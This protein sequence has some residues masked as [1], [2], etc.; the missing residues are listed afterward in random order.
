MLVSLSSRNLVK[1]LQNIFQICKECKNLGY[2]MS[3]V[4]I[5]DLETGLTPRNASKNYSNLQTLEKFR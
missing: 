4:R 5:R 3:L 1:T 2:K